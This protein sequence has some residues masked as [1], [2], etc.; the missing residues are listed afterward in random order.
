MA[1]AET[2][3]KTLQLQMLDLESEVIFEFEE[4]EAELLHLRDSTEELGRQLK[5]SEQKRCAPCDLKLLASPW[6]PAAGVQRPFSSHPLL[7]NPRFPHSFCCCHRRAVEQEL[8]QGLE[9]QILQMSDELLSL[10]VRAAAS[11]TPQRCSAMRDSGGSGCSSASSPEQPDT[12]GQQQHPAGGCA[13]LYARSLSMTRAQQQLSGQEGFVLRS[14]HLKLEPALICAERS[15][16][17]A[18]NTSAMD[19]DMAT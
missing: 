8:R 11:I 1:A 17:T 18:S 15:G 10:R 2:E 9:L 3:K 5:E 7:C 16:S 4:L 19:M 6:R 13:H 12:P 14:N